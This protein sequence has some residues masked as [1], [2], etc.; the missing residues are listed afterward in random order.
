MPL[1]PLSRRPSFVTATVALSFS[2]AAI[3]PAHAH[4]VL[5]A[6][7]N[8]SPELSVPEEAGKTLHALRIAGGEL[9]IDGKLD[10]RVW[11]QADSI[12]D[13]VQWEPD[14]MQPMSE[15]TVVRVAYD[16]RYIYVAV[17]CHDSHP[18]EIATGLG[19]RDRFPPSDDFWVGFDPRHDHLTGYAY[20]TN[21]SGLQGDFS[22]FDDENF[23]GDY[24]AVWEVA[25]RLAADGWTAEYQIP[26]SQMRFRV[27]GRGEV[28]WGFTAQR[29]IY[30][31]GEIGYWVGRPRGE[32]GQVSRWGH[33]V[34]SEG[35]T[36][37]RRLEVMPYSSARRADLTGHGSAEYDLNAGVDLRIGLGTATTLSATINPDFAQVEVDPA[38]L[39]LS[40]FESFFPEKRAFFLEDSRTFRPPYGLFR[41]FH[42]RRIGNRPD[43]FS[44][45]ANDRLV[46]RP[47]ETTILG[48]SKITGKAR[49]WTYGAVSVVTAREYATVDSV[50][51]GPA[52]VET[53]TRYSR[54]IEPLTS[55]SAIRVQRD[56]LG[57]SSNIGVLA[58]SVVRERDADAL[59]GGIDYKFR[60]DRNRF[61]WNGHWAV[62]HAPG[63]GGVETG[64][65][66]V[67]NF[68]R[69]A[70]HFGF[71]LH[72]DHFG[73]TFRVNDLG[74]QFNRT[75]RTA[76]D[77]SVFVEQPDPWSMFRSAG[78]WTEFGQAWNGNKVVFGRGG[79]MGA[80]ANF[81]NFWD[82]EVWV[83][84]DLE[85]LD[86]LDTRGGP[87]IVSPASTSLNFQIGTDA[88][89][90]WRVRNRLSVTTDAAGGWS[91]HV[92]PSLTVQPSARLQASLSGSYRFG[93]TA[94]QWIT[95]GDVDGD[96]ETD[97]V[98]GT[99]RRDVID[100]TVRATYALHR[101]LSLEM[102]L[103][104]FVAVGA[105]TD[106]RQLAAPRSFEFVPATIPFDPDFNSKSLR[107]T[108]VMR[109]EFV[110]GSTLFVVWN[111]STFNDSRSGVF[112]P[113]KDLAGAFSGDGDRILMIKLNYWLS[114]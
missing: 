79:G 12:V 80:W 42:S 31:R 82:A 63:P 92:G 34:F 27:P 2:I 96:G 105:Y 51:V 74:F 76:L 101:D 58:T 28:V 38:V 19:R 53:L 49:G 97:N 65:G 24:D 35:L 111:L 44:L 108:V 72:A 66:G 84:R 6:T 99:L 71:S 87:L 39:N 88:R 1:S 67:T 41:L 81:R 30:R 86:D 43:R 75:D 91:A 113:F 32:R 14:N 11:I 95:N 56:V 10:E 18:S 54:M 73:R 17:Y 112:S 64:F 9:S 8:P 98:Y 109:W 89:K 60:W 4:Q 114:S 22:W 90:G 50:G 85:V 107:G 62:T 68:S 7:P 3:A 13:F 20:R 59:A 94:A 21:P 93:R 23:D 69:S 36:A 57:G 106:I 5:P 83:S 37:P 61:E 45:G 16:D 15:R 70:K 40:V 103:Q 102:F 29:E 33:L 26:L 48:A 100:V 25:T 47:D 52:G 55:Y 104:P 77:L 46:D 78:F 110:R